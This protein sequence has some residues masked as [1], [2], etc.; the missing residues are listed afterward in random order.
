MCLL[1]VHLL[2]SRSSLCLYPKNGL[3]LWCFHR[4][5]LW[6]RLF[7]WVGRMRV[8]F[9][10]SFLSEWSQYWGVTRVKWGQIK[11]SL[12]DKLRIGNW[13]DT[14]YSWPIFFFYHGRKDQPTYCARLIQG[15]PC[16]RSSFYAQSWGNH[17]HSP[18]I[19]TH[20]LCLL[21]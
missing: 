1:A 10:P 13:E 6:L 4:A 2:Q 11:T 15:H 19:F 20:F 14:N 8:E 17:I 21:S 18:S 9:A 16:L 12:P 3:L 5:S 7:L